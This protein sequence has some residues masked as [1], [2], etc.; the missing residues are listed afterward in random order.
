MLYI[1]GRSNLH[2]TAMKINV[3][4]RDFSVG[5]P[6]LWNS[7]PV[8]LMYAGNITTFRHQLKT[9]LFQLAYPP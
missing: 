5:F 6:T 3:G 2:I 4:T 7:L 1:Q 8:S 9:H